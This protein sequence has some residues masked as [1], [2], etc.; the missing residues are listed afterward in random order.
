MVGFLWETL[1]ISKI[2]TYRFHITVLHFCETKN[3][4]NKFSIALLVCE[5][6]GDYE[7]LSVLG[8]PRISVIVRAIEKARTDQYIN[9]YAESSGV[10][11]FCLE[12]IFTE[13]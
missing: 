7:I 13:I 9:F 11:T 4:L 10:V 2:D 12:K 8:T 5:I 3:T 6:Q 1:V